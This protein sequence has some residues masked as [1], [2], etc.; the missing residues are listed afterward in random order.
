MKYR[1][2]LLLCG[3]VLLAGT[4]WAGF[5]HKAPP[6]GGGGGGGGGTTNTISNPVSVPEPSALPMLVLGLGSVVLL[7]WRRSKVA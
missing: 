6:A 5:G 2:G 3:I 7:G 1:L 4:S